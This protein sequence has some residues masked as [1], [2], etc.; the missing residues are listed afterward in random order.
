MIS[1]KILLHPEKG[2]TKRIIFIIILIIFIA[3]FFVSLYIEIKG[4]QRVIIDFWIILFICIFDFCTIIN[5]RNVLITI[6]PNEAIVYEYHGKY[7]G[8]VKETGYFYFSQYGKIH[9]I[10]LKTEEFNGNKI[11]VCERDWNPVELG[12]IVNY[13]VEDTAKAIFNV[14]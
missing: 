1:E 4:I 10:S 14:L 11:K 13:K 9:K 7:I 3:L 8:T 6:E 5:C 12:I 2:Y